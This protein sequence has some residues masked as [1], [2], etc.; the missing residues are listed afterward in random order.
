MSNVITFPI[1]NRLNSISTKS[2]SA[3][4]DYIKNDCIEFYQKQINKNEKAMQKLRLAHGVNREEFHKLDL[5]T[6]SKY[7]HLQNQNFLFR[8]AIWNLRINQIEME[9]FES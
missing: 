7:S 4:I 2:L 3:N 1:E 8:S 5:E 9:Q 6:F